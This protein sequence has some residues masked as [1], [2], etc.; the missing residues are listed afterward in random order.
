MNRLFLIFIAAILTTQT[1]HAQTD[2]S[3]HNFEVA[4][5]LEIFNSLY[6][7]LD[8]YYVDTLNAE[9]NINNALWYMLSQLDPFTEYYSEEN[10]SGFRQLATG[11]YAGVGSL[12]SL[13]RAERRCIIAEPFEGM[14]AAEAG[15]L[16][17]DIILSQDGQ[18]YGLAEAGK[19]AEYS[20]RVSASL[21]GD[22]GTSFTL[23]VKR[24]GVEEP[25]TVRLTRRNITLPSVVCAR[26]LTD[27]IGYLLMDSYKEQTA[28]D[29]RLALAQLKQQGARRLILDLRNN[30]G[31]LIDQAVEVVNLFLPKGVEVVSLRGRSG[32]EKGKSYTTSAEPFDAE[33]PVVVLVSN[34]TAS[35]AEITS[36]AL[37]D[38]DRAVV[39][40]QRTY[41]KGLVQQP[42]Q[43]P[44]STML[45]LTT[46]KYYI[47]SGRCIQAYSYKNGI[48]QHL[49]DSL[50]REFHTAGGRIVRDGGGIQPDV[51][52]K[53]DSL[54]SLL[55]Y[56][57]ASDALADYVSDYCQRHATI[58]PPAEFHLTDEEY[59]DFR[60]FV[61]T[62][63]FTYDT[64]SK[65]ALDILR[66]IAAAE[67]YTDVTQDE[68]KA[69]ENKLAHNTDYDFDYWQ[70]DIRKL[71]EGRIVTARYY[72]RGAAEH[73][74]RGDREVAEALRILSNDASYRHILSTAASTKDTPRTD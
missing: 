48:P 53:P 28:R 15:L 24:Y 14:P 68:F 33:M 16:A 34:S 21:R 6:R 8:L 37:Q 54:P 12:V 22:A 10:T 9:K 56:L 55:D 41:G 43:L 39:I 60:Q 38:Y 40:G 18:D 71:V 19:E 74:L 17:G 62:H 69:L 2:G 45:K 5:N 49:P 59:A 61:K 30:P 36:G 7:E 44:Y 4:K 63:G 27:S 70:S 25:I 66:Q 32:T 57:E 13:R 23:T 72:Q 35:A 50:A 46:A 29:V 73:A 51:E 67:G 20:N 58:A 31:G 42:R 65:A 1:L 52:L 26:L 11:K 3:A 64:R 47:P